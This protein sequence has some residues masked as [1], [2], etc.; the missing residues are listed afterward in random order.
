MNIDKYIGMEI[1]GYRWFSHN[2]G[3]HSFQRR[4]TDGYRWE[5]VQCTEEQLHNGDIEFMTEHGWTLSKEQIRDTYKL[6]KK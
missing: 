3:V 4:T 5:L 6:F 1:N 2:K